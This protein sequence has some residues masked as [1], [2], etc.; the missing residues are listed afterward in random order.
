MSEEPISLLQQRR[1]EAAVV[2][3]LV[4]AFEAELGREKT[5]AIL[6]N[7][8]TQLA[9]DAGKALA[10]TAP[11]TSLASFAAM[12][13]LWTRGDALEIEVLKQTRTE[14]AFNVTRCRYAEMY[15]E[16]GLD[17]LGYTLSCNR[18]G[19]LMAGFA[20][21]VE[22]ARTQTIMQGASHCDFRYRKREP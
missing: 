10:K 20:P 18:D 1:I 13:E 22:F 21:D 19:A 9:H 7:V 11:D 3:P 17:E 16:L 4:Q 2:K 12:S 8:I 6:A 5:R 15:R 14:Y